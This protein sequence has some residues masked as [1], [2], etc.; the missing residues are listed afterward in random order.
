[1]RVF[2]RNPPPIGLD[3][4]E[5]GTVSWRSKFIPGLILLTGGGWRRGGS[6][7]PLNQTPMQSTQRQVQKKLI[8][9]GLSNNH[10]DIQ[11]VLDIEQFSTVK[12]VS[13][14]QN[15]ESILGST[16]LYFLQIY[17]YILYGR[18]SVSWF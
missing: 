2:F 16:E 12:G 1:M 5:V 8:I 14:D 7:L 13:L 3:V 17:V 6:N 11:D 9:P 18:R 4:A 15:D 10:H